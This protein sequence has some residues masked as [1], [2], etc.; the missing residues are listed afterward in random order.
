MRDNNRVKPVRLPEKA[1]DAIKGFSKPIRIE[2]GEMLTKLQLGD[3]LGLPVS[4]PMPSIAAGSHELR[5]KDSAGIYRVFYYLK[6]RESI[7]VFHAFT[8]KRKKHRKVK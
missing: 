2:V 7:L 4:R 6:F 1:R 5:L 8:K 3:N